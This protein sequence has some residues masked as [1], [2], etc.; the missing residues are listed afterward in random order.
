[1]LCL[2]QFKLFSRQLEA[3][4]LQIGGNNEECIYARLADLPGWAETS[5]RKYLTC[6]LLLAVPSTMN[7]NEEATEFFTFLNA[8]RPHPAS[9][10][11]LVLSH[12]IMRTCH[13]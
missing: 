13:D 1:M 3:S 10:A 8:T 6:R 4:V 5:R 12:V 9:F 2:H 7:Q 11:T